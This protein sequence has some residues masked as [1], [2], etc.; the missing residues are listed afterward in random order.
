MRWNCDLHLHQP[1][2]KLKHMMSAQHRFN[3]T[4]NLEMQ[5]TIYS[6][7]NIDT[8]CLIITKSQSPND[9]VFFSL[10]G[11]HKWLKQLVNFAQPRNHQ[12]FTQLPLLKIFQPLKS[13]WIFSMLY[14]V[15][16]DSYKGQGIFTIGLYL[17]QWERT[18]L[19]HLLKHC[20]LL[21]V[22][23]HDN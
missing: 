20:K 9:W 4:G 3:R 19:Q 7:T 5:D 16:R 8:A 13:K 17:R 6:I 12:A 10:R 15:P 1:I 23:K 21:K 18:A 11:I 2:R 22:A 14:K